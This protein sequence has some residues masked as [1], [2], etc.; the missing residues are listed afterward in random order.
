MNT[1][2]NGLI[3]KGLIVFSVLLISACGAK[4]AELNVNIIGEG[5]VTAPSGVDCS[6]SCVAMVRLNPPTIGNKIVK[7]TA[8][9]APGYE[10][11]GWNNQ[12]CTPDEVCNMKFSGLCVDQLFC[13]TGTMYSGQR[14]EAIFVDSSL[15]VDS[16]WS[17]QSI[18]AV[19]GDDE[20]QCWSARIDEV[21]QVPALNN[22][23]KV[24]VGGYSACAL[25]DEGVSC[26]GRSNFL[27][28]GAPQL[29]P[30]L[31]MEMLSSQICVL[32]QEGV[33]C[34]GRNGLIDTPEFTNPTNLRK[35]HVED[36]DSIRDVFCVD[37][38]GVEVCW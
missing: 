3:S 27:P 36:P 18:C 16:G 2:F 24:A 32:D 5:S 37:D 20:V 29:Y 9:P 13:S 23:Q 28:T 26:W 6:E 15:L 11:L 10:F 30:P 1:Y 21:E 19:L 8:T 17:E 7:I 25:V 33:K 35:R 22:P 12:Y 14:V 4:E 38:V 31:D 34:W